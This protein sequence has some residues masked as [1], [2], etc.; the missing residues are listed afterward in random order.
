MCCKWRRLKEVVEHWL[1]RTNKLW[2]LNSYFR[3]D[4]CSWEI[5]LKKWWL[6]NT[7]VLMIMTKTAFLCYR[8]P[9]AWRAQPPNTA[10]QSPEN[11]SSAGG[12][13]RDKHVD[14]WNML[15]IHMLHWRFHDLYRHILQKEIKHRA[16]EILKRCFIISGG[17]TSF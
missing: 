7:W 5:G 15:A 4:R 1:Y 16:S 8:K 12:F 9:A 6:W 3:T 10:G 14:T 11:S 17:T 13:V 2:L